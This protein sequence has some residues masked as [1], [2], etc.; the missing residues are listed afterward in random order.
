MTSPQEIP[1]DERFG[2][3]KSFLVNQGVSAIEVEEKYSR[4]V[5]ELRTD[6]YVPESAKA[7]MYKVLREVVEEHTTA[8]KG[9]ST[10]AH[11]QLHC[12]ALKMSRP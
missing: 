4:W 6:R 2:M 11:L 8:S 5:T 3:L 10:D 12:P 1:R 7:K 9:E